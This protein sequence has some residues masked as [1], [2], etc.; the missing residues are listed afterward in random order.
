MAQ[1]LNGLPKEGTLFFLKFYTM[2]LEL[3]KDCFQ[4]LEVFCVLFSSDKDNVE[5]DTLQ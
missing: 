5:W 2:V 3:M 1:V 4:I